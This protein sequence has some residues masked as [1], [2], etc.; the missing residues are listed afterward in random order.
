MTTCMD[1]EYTRGATGSMRGFT[2]WAR[3]M[4]TGFIHGLM[5]VDMKE[6]GSAVSNKVM[7]FILGLT[8]VD[9]KA[10]GSTVS[11]KVMEFIL[12]LTAVDMKANG[13]TVSGVDRASTYHQTEGLRLESGKMETELDGLINA[14]IIK[15][16]LT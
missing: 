3:S 4:V 14:H 9:M 7:E 11:N 15:V 16:N 8:A 10:I 2:K 1:K 12:G 5:A 13:S 6:I